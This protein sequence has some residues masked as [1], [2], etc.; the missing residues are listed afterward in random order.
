[1][2]RRDPELE[3][4]IQERKTVRIGNRIPELTARDYVQMAF[5]KEKVALSDILRL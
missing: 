1:M 5:S 4:L 3:L 2:I